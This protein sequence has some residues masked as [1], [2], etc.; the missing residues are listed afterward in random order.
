MKGVASRS[1]K[2]ALRGCLGS[3]QGGT[4][5]EILPSL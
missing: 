4:A 1:D 5:E 3:K 2:I